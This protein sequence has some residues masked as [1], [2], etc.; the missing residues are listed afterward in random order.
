MAA[1]PSCGLIRQ[2]L[3][4]SIPHPRSSSQGFPRLPLLQKMFGSALAARTALA[5]HDLRSWTEHCRMS[6]DKCVILPAEKRQLSGTWRGVCDRRIIALA[7]WLRSMAVASGCGMSS[8][9]RSASRRLGL[10]CGPWAT[11]TLLPLPP[12]YPELNRCENV[13]QFRRDSWLWNRIFSSY[14]NTVDHCCFAWNR[15][16]DQP[17]RI[18]TLGPRT[19]AHRS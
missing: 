10:R 13:W 17:W 16:T 4:L 7:R 14:D 8:R 1:M 11:A 2:S 19:W 6:R 9:S 12:K 5:D 15:L 18:M 3:Q